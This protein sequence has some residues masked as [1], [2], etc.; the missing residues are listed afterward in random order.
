M[1]FSGND[2]TASLSVALD[3]VGI[4]DQNQQ[5]RRQKNEKA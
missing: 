5:V 4:C 1:D 2:I 3:F